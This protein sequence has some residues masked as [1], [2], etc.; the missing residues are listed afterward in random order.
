MS[1]V[2]TDP[3]MSP[4]VRRFLDDLEKRTNFTNLTV[5]TLT[6]TGNM[7]EAGEEVLTTAGGETIEAGFDHLMVDLGTPVAA[8]TQTI[9]PEGGFFQKLT[10][11]A[12]FVLSPHATKIG[13]CVL[14]I[15]NG[16]AAGAVTFTGWTKKYPSGSL[17]TTNTNK[18]AL[19]LFFYGSL[20]ADYSIQ[21]RQ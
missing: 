17:D 18:F 5:E 14:H 11:N 16:A 8:S 10:N 15:T 3:N 4:E 19:F 2:P 13:S 1:K 7:T 20:G 6:V 21:P 12:A 9:D